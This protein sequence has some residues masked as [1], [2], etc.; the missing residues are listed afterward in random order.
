MEYFNISPLHPACQAVSDGSLQCRNKWT[1]R[2]H[3]TRSDVHEAHARISLRKRSQGGPPP[4]TDAIREWIE[5]NQ[6][7]RQGISEA[8]IRAAF[9]SGEEVGLG[10]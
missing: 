3:S 9:S 8:D 1:I 7:W 2:I 6:E 10:H 5:Q 4:S